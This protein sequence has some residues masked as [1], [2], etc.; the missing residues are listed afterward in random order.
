[1]KR[2]ETDIE[3]L[4]QLRGV[5]CGEYK[6]LCNIAAERI[7]RLLGGYHKQ[8]K[9]SAELESRLNL[10]NR[11]ATDWNCSFVG[12]RIPRKEKLQ[13]SER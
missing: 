4:A 10:I 5:D 1:M 7:E 2:P 6:A 3:L 8:C 11:L 9:Q 13:H 12:V